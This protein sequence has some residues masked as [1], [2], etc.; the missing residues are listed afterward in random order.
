MRPRVL[1][2]GYVGALSLVAGLLL[3]GHVA[4]EGVVERQQGDAR[5]I[6]LAGRQRMLGQRLCMLL[7]A[8]GV[9]DPEA[10]RATLA[11]LE[12]TADDWERSQRALRA[13]DG[14]GTAE[15]V[16]SMFEQ[17]EGDHRAML[18]AAR[19]AIA[20]HTVAADHARLAR[21][22]EDHFLAGMDR[23]V[24][25]YERAA[26]ARVAALHRRALFVLVLA[27]VALALEGALVF[28]PA[29]RGVRDH[30]AARD[31]TQRAL[32]ARERQLL[33]ISDREQARLA[34]DLHDGLGQHLIGVA[35]LVRALRGGQ[36]GARAAQLDEIEALLAEA[37]EQTRDLARGLHPQTLEV[38]GLAAALGELAA[39][40]KRVYGIPCRVEHR[41]AGREPAP[42][43]RAHLYRIARE[44]VLNAAKHAC[45]TEIAIELRR[46]G[47]GLSLVVRDDGVGMGARANGGMGLHLMAY[48]ARMMGATL[49]IAEG[50][51]GGTVVTCELPSREAIATG[52]P[53]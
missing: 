2:F 9:D 21:A 45:A 25:E 11:E 26:S 42:Q 36:P 16:R 10:A 49:T 33:Q 32:E 20:R 15:R 44:A 35:F 4:V 34:Q 7:L 37:I 40:A 53:P 30:L 48:R 46:A 24:L 23:I 38:A 39:H 13:N 5:A 3:A 8:L 28:R 18:A 6:N 47:A 17:I 19:A 1:T 31:A 43:P 41:T 51:R 22:H 27:L 52:G 14:D 29:V 12:R 50:P